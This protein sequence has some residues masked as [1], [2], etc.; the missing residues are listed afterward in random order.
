VTVRNGGAAVLT[1]VY[2]LLHRSRA[3]STGRAPRGLAGTAAPRAVAA[4]PDLWLIAANAPAV[5]YDAAAIER[6]LKDL[7]WVAR[8][9][10]GHARVVEHFSATGT[11]LPMRLFTLFRSDARAV[12]H[13]ARSRA[14]LERDLARVAGRREWG[15]R[16]S[17]D[18]RAARARARETVRRRVGPGPDGTRFLVM[19][20]DE[21]AVARHLAAGGRERAR[22]LHAR[23]RR[24]ADDVRT[25]PPLEAA[26]DAR[27]LLDAAFLV[28]GAREVAF[29]KAV[30]RESERLAGEGFGVTLTGPWPPY[31]FVGARR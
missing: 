28:R 2:C 23:L 29:R 7:D 21:M 27:L 30:R 26:G 8:R 22:D 24:H 4:G 15:V 25:R 14:R 13:V 31:S 9:A 11:V 12:A 16:L 20:R 1:Y 3:P 6:G 18:V 17:L 10:L 19:K 5:A